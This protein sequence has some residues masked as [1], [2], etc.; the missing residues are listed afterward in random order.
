MEKQTLS[1]KISSDFYNRLRSHIG[2]G[3]IS[4]FIEKVVSKELSDQEKKLELEYSK[5][6]SNP[7]LL[8]EAGQWEKAEIES[9][10]AYEKKK[11][12]GK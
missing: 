3:K 11:K 4:E 6:Y 2:K 10:L 5:A 8:K 7:Q 1:I 12:D 9:W